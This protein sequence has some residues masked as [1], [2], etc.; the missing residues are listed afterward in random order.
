MKA[1]IKVTIEYLSDA[2]VSLWTKP[3]NDLIVGV[4][5][6]VE[7]NEGTTINLAPADSLVEVAITPVNG[8]DLLYVL[9][10]ETIDLRLNAN[11]AVVN[12]IVAD[13]LDSTDSKYGLY[14]T[15]CSGITSLFLT[16]GGTSAAKVTLMYFGK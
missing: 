11:N 8:A 9:T 12:T 16:N 13:R 10:T 2:G 7:A 4:A 5:D 3:A 14:L 1:K 15:T 6:I